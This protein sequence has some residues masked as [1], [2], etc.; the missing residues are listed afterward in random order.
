MEEKLLVVDKLTTS[1]HLQNGW[2]SAIQDRIFLLPSTAMKRLP[3]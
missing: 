1:F 2:F 3:W